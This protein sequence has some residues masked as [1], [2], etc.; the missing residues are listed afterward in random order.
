MTEVAVIVCIGP[1]NVIGIKDKLPWHS[2]QDFY[3]FKKQTKGYPCIF[4]DKTFFGLPK[5][6]LK[7]RLNIV[8][9]LDY[10]K[11]EVIPCGKFN[12]EE[13]DKMNFNNI[14]SFIKVPTVE[15]GI[16]LAKNFSKIFICGGASIYKY[17]LENKLVN[18]V[19]LTKII[20]PQ[21]EKDI[22]ENPNNYIRFPIDFQKIFRDNWCRVA[23][24]YDKDELPEE[25]NEFIV[26]FQKWIKL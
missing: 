26:Q 12:R 13:D 25:N 24:E 22:K 8:A 19:Y 18:T 16:N 23:F 6:P 5:Y 14:G 17:C 1:D 11:T 3:H 21:L 2:K 15:E 9:S 10:D 4:G 20:C 7:D